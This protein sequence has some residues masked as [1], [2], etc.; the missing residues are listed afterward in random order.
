M[1]REMIFFVCSQNIV[2]WIQL[3]N[4]V[5]IKMKTTLL[6]VDLMLVR[7]YCLTF[8]FPV[9]IERTLENVARNHLAE[10]I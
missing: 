3:G 10:A 5:R 9:I 2:E 7:V 8:G 4:G 6:L 1:M